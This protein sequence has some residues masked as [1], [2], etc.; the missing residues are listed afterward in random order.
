MKV[1][2][3]LVAIADTRVTSGTEQITA[4]KISVHQN[5]HHAIFAMTS[6]LRS[7]RDKALTYFNEVLDDERENCDKLY[8]AVNLLAQQI[9]RVSKEDKQALAEA[10]LDFNLFCIVGGQLEADS[11]HKLFMLYPQGNWVEVGE[12]N[13]YF[14]IGE[15]SYAK[16]VMDRTIRFDSPLDLA[17]KVGFLGFNAARASTTDVGFPVDVVM[18]RRDSYRMAEHRYGEGDL[19]EMSRWWDD[20]IRQSVGEAPSD[21]IGPAMDKLRA[22]EHPK[23]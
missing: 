7:V 1:R 18:Y 16:P 10:G 19:A 2:D 3:G 20:R 8:K 12:G 23:P 11:E 4:R 5:G 9:R 22:I 21:W 15:S 13:P 17:L 6:G 14:A